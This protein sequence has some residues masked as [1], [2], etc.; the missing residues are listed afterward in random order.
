[1]KTQSLYANL[2]P[3]IMKVYS[4]AKFWSTRLAR[5]P[6]ICESRDIPPAKIELHKC[7]CVENIVISFQRVDCFRALLSHARKTQQKK[8]GLSP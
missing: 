6:P 7:I 2:P 1:M 4:W 8:V 5:F 3:I